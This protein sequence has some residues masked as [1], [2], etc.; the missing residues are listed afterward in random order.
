MFGFLKKIP[1]KD[2]LLLAL[3]VGSISFSSCT[4]NP[5]TSLRTPSL[6][7]VNLPFLRLAPSGECYYIDDFLPTPDTMVTGRSGG[8]NLRYYTYWTARYKTWADVGIMLSFYSKDTRCWSL[9]EEY[10]LAKPDEPS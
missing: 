7:P 10:V 5:A 2:L 1:K 9:F 6:I 3:A 4:T 8:L